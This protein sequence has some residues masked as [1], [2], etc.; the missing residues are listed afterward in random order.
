M[1]AT[2]PLFSALQL[3]IEAIFK[4]AAKY[5]PSN[6]THSDFSAKYDLHDI[7]RTQTALESRH[8]ASAIAFHSE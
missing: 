5:R 1:L 7:P 4:D 2:H 6:S 3:R 8:T